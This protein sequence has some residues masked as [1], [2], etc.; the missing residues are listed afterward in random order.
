MKSSPASGRGPTSRR[1][2]L[3]QV[4]GAATAARIG[5]LMTPVGGATL[6]A[7]EDGRSNDRRRAAAAYSIRREAA[8]FQKDLPLPS[9]LT[10]HDDDRYRTFIGSYSKGLMHNGLG[11]VDTE[12][13]ETLRRAL[14]SG[15][16]EDFALVPL[17]GVAKLA[18]PQAALAF[19]IDGADSHH[20]GIRVPPAFSSAEEAGEMAELYWQALTRDVPFANYD[21]DLDIATAAASLSAFSDFR[22][23]KIGGKVTPATLFRGN[24]PGDLAGPYL[25]Q[26]LWKPVPYGP[27]SITQTLKPGVAGVQYLTDYATWL[28]IQNGAA[29]GTYALDPLPRY[30]HNNRTLT[31][32]VHAD[33]S[34]QAYLNAALTLLATPASLATSNPYRTSA[35]QAGFATFGGPDVVDVVAHVACL[36]LK[37]AWY[38][39]W[40]VHRRLRPEAFGGAIHNTKAGA[41]YPINA[42][43]LDSSVLHAVQTR[44]GSYLLPMAYPEGSPL[45]PSYP[46]GHAAIAG[47]C[48][49]V[50]K[51]FFNEAAE[52]PTPVVASSDGAVLNLYGGSLTVGGELNKLASNIAIGRDAAGVHWRSDGIEGLNLGEAVAIHLLQD[53]RRCYN[54]SFPGFRFTRFDGTTMTI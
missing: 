6:N 38:Q 9:H 47:G 37:A 5:T 46:A 17:G 32:Y 8:V 26:F 16:P 52:I 22:G 30:I 10:N 44:Y 53:L 27:Y 50:L 2:F 19:Q 29:A 25:S 4:G 11:E 13:Y 48:V 40:S 3:T 1:T 39:K 24:T 28:D 14:H 21:V 43:I 49:T 45:H 23:P 34:Y 31:A 42:E 35:N 33:F 41:K 54:E 12:A 51:A 15:E 36:T 20:L 7:D 18:D